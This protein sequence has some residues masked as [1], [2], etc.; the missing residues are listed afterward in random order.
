MHKPLRFYALIASMILAGVLLALPGHS[1]LGQTPDSTRLIFGTVLDRQNQP[2]AD[3][4]VTLY[5]AGQPDPL[6]ET[7]T[8]PNG[9][10]ALPLPD[11]LP[12]QLS[13]HVEHEHFQ[14]AEVALDAT[15]LQN[16]QAGQPVSLPD[17][18]LA[19]QVT[20]SLFIATLVFI[21]MLVLIGLTKFHNT[22]AALLGM[23]VIFAV[24]Y[25]GRPLSNEL[26]ILDFRGALHYIDWNVIF[27]IMGMMIVIAV[28]ERT[29]IFQWL[30]FTAYRISHGRLWL[31][32]IILMIVTGIASAALD[33]VTT[34]LLMTPITVQIALALDINPLSLLMPE[35]LASNVAG[36]STLIGTPTNILIGSYAKLSF[37][38][39]LT[40][41]TPGVL[42]ALAG[43]I[44][45]CL[46]TY[47]RELRPG[48]VGG[49]SSLL[50]NKLAE[51]ARITEPVHLKKAGVIGALMLI[52][53]VTG[54]SIHLIPAVTALMGATALL[55]WIRPD[56]EEMIEAVDWTTLVFFM[57]LFVVIGAMQEVGLISFI[58]D[59]IGQIVG[60]SLLLAVIIVLWFSALI[61]A[62]IDNIPF[63]AAMLPVVGYLTATVPGAQSNVLFF[64]LSVGSAMGG[65]G[66]LVGSSANMVTAGIAD[67]AGY[68]ITY[69]YFFKKGFP[70]LLITVG[71]ATLWLV[72]HFLINNPAAP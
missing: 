30:A 61:S 45:Y 13:V 49:V 64:C 67:R 44:L 36:I 5:A 15:A 6:E 22:L 46:Y 65:N 21:G 27:L 25:L 16:L 69:I 59:G 34:M 32:M 50:L 1:A 14:S 52:L 43:L 10:Y 8:Q 39:F 48:G 3:A 19:R 71:L 26:F 23:V 53:F 40:N 55:V 62:L 4:R 29:G 33:N 42:L 31:L 24:S 7:L 58:A 47:R 66:T 72:F 56:I 63:T 41:L 37:N 68:P 51:R 38:D 9:S 28:V 57:S 70:A 17:T 20:L 35:V 2:V 54:E 18:V 12:D 11:T 60:S